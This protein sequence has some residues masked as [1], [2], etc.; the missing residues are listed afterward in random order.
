[1]KVFLSALMG[2]KRGEGAYMMIH[3]DFKTE[4]K[5]KTKYCDERDDHKISLCY[6]NLAILILFL[7]ML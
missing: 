5:R 2:R 6:Q 3:Q 7:L 4:Q 1:M